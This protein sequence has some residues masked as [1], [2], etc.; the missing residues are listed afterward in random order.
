MT[1]TY[2]GQCSLPLNKIKEEYIMQLMT[3]E[4]E[5]KLSRHPFGSQE[6]KGLDA[7]VIVKYFYPYGLDIFIF[8]NG[9]GGMSG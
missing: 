1:S 9:S 2:K 4:I 6:S 8:M 5:K 3:K 7:E